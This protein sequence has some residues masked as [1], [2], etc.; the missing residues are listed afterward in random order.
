MK[1]YKQRSNEK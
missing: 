1:D